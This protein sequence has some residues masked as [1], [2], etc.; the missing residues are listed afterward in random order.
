MA[1]AFRTRRDQESHI[2][3]KLKFSVLAHVTKWIIW[4]T[5]IWNS[6]AFADWRGHFQHTALGALDGLCN[7]NPTGLRT[8]LYIQAGLT[9][10]DTSQRIAEQWKFRRK[11]SLEGHSIVNS[12][13]MLS[14]GPNPVNARGN[15]RGFKTR[16]NHFCFFTFLARRNCY[17]KSLA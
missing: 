1:L 2:T 10:A 12:R 14:G 7:W 3:S 6:L 8:P 5:T 16:S 11:C 17:S 15:R 13:G 9:I 4:S